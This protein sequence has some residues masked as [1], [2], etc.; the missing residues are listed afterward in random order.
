MS[1]FAPM[2]FWLLVGHALCDFSLQSDAMARGKNRH[3]PLTN[4]PPGA[5]PTVIWPYWLGAHALIHGGAVALITGSVAFGVLEFGFHVMIDVMKCENITT[6]HQDQ[7][8][9][10][11][12]KLAITAAVVA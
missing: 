5:K 8:L 6:L 4:V 1:A 12:C 2:F 3:S 9:H 10:V 7:A 11:L